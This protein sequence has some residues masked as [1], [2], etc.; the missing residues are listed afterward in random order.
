LVSFDGAEGSNFLTPP[1]TTMP[2]PM[3]EFGRQL[4]ERLV[5]Q[6]VGKKRPGEVILLSPQLAVRHVTH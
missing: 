1:L 3:Y 5:D 6:L 2:V 4:A